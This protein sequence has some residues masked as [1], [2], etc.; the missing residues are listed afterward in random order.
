L[1]PF[2]V[3]KTRLQGQLP[4]I[5]HKNYT[6]LCVHPL[7]HPHGGFFFKRFDGLADTWCYECESPRPA[8]KFNGTIDTA[9]KL[10]QNEGVHSLWRGWSA[11]LLRSVPQIVIYFSI[12]EHLK[13]NF[14]KFKVPL[15]PF[16]A[17]GLA[18]TVTTVAVSPIELIRTKQQALPHSSSILSVLNSELEKQ[19]GFR[20]LWRG[21]APTLLRDVPFSAFYWTFFETFRTKFLQTY[22]QNWSSMS[23]GERNRTNT[24]ASFVAGASSGT[25]A[26]ILTHPFDLVKTRRQIEL[27]EI[28]QDKK[29]VPSTT[30]Q[31]LQTILKEEG[32]RGLFTGWIPRVA[33]I[34]PAC[35]IMISTYEFAK[36]YFRES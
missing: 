20:N 23:T 28:Q 26:A 30:K 31:I 24:L 9:I 14:E 16:F 36:A 18:R 32:F 7:Q 29:A 15:T 33:E 27:Y 13:D 4:T 2:D 34:A 35:A 25:I 19:N 12:Y 8:L 17:G 5:A 11:T 1:T 6:A 21:A 10:A 3:V 22:N